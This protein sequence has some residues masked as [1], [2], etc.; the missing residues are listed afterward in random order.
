MKQAIGRLLA[1]GVWAT[2][3]LWVPGASAT[4]EAVEGVT[5]FEEAVTVD[6]RKRHALYFR[7]AVA[8]TTKAPLLVLLH[9]RGGDGEAMNYL[10]EASRLSRDFG[11]WVVLPDAKNHNW[12]HD[13]ADTGRVDDVGYLSSL[14][15]SAVSRFPL[16]AKRVYM[17]GLSDGGFMAMRYAC[18]QPGRIAAVATV[19]ATLLKKLDRVCQPSLGT[20]MLMINGTQDERTRYDST[21]GVLTVPDTAARWAQKDGCPAGPKRTALPDLAAD[22]TTVVLDT[23][24][25]CAAGEVRLYT[26]T[27][28]GH[29]WPG[30][31]RDTLMYG[32]TS[33]DIDATLTIWEFVRRF[34]R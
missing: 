9:Y 19:A 22:R 33:H 1:L 24:S 21:W 12:N 2:L 13:P 31:S 14:I 8:G 4:I 25:A 27:N 10:T 34:S 15:D 28:G 29:T 6:G 20:P 3:W 5:H 17:A 26:V 32:R 16:D 7:P 18:E 11:I 23:W 30:A